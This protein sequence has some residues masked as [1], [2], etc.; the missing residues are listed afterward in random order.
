M[1]LLVLFEHVESFLIGEARV[2]DDLDTVAHALLDRGAG[3]GMAATRL[4][5]ASPRRPDGDL[6]VGHRRE[7]GR[8]PRDIL[9]GE[10]EL[11]RVDTVFEEHA[12]GAAHLLG[13]LTTARS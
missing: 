2:I 5:A 3:P 13:P 10:I 11:H 4:R 1:L 12:H 9:A 6:A 7:L 8:D